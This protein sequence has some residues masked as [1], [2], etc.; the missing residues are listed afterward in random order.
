M[1][2]LPLES[3]T[4]LNK[5]VEDSNMEMTKAILI[6]KHSTRCSIS[7]IAKFRLESFWENDANFPAYYLDLLKF[8][9]LSNEISE[10]FSVHHESPQVL[11]IKNGKCIFNA[12]HLN[13]SVKSI[14]ATV[15]N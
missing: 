2:W 13:I 12:S 4:D 3:L 15:K 7:S 14:L 9:L 8:R 1:N 5:V 10:R 11:I 6:F